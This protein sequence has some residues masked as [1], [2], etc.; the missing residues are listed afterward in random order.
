MV[1]SFVLPTRCT[2]VPPFHFFDACETVCI[3]DAYGGASQG[4]QSA[5]ASKM[6]RTPQVV[7]RVEEQTTH[8]KGDW[9]PLKRWGI[10]STPPQVPSFTVHLRW[11]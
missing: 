9:A 11:S 3:C 10:P 7:K 2:F 4:E 1:P 5:D 8:A 6:Q